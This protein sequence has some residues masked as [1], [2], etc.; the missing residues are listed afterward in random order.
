MAKPLSILDILP[1]EMVAKIG[2]YAD[3]STLYD[4]RLSCKSM[5]TITELTFAKR[6]FSERRHIFS[7]H[8]LEELVA[9]TAHPVFGRHVRT[10]M[11]GHT[12]LSPFGLE[13][14]SA[15]Y[16]DDHDA[17]CAFKEYSDILEE[18]K[19]LDNGGEALRLL[20]MAMVNIASHHES[21]V[22][23]SWPDT[24]VRRETWNP[25][26]MS[27]IR[28]HWYSCEIWY[29]GSG[30]LQRY[31]NKI[32]FLDPIATQWIEYEDKP[33]AALEVLLQA[34]MEAGCEVNTMKLCFDAWKDIEPG[35]F[36]LLSEQAIANVRI[37]DIAICPDLEYLTEVLSFDLIESIL[38]TAINVHTVMFDLA[39][40][41][42]DDFDEL[43]VSSIVKTGKL[44]RLHLSNGMLTDESL[45][46]LLERQKKSLQ[47]LSLDAVLV[48]GTQPENDESN[49]I[50]ILPWMRQNLLSLTRLTLKNMHDFS[51]LNLCRDCATFEGSHEIR[52]G[53]QN[54]LQIVHE[55]KDGCQ[56][57]RGRMRI[58]DPEFP[59]SE[60]SS[61]KPS[62]PES[63]DPAA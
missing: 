50:A 39:G 63:S 54:L 27:F 7:K 13:S 58:L 10:V 3:K 28:Y 37:I 26:E 16:D 46:S 23:G 21:I 8:S 18:Q 62:L 47:D 22:I 36:V 32:L 55:N 34:A 61:P 33:K 2:D 53:F 48:C 51:F 56:H 60:T 40:F 35:P 52:R 15:M 6:Y 43:G 30:Q 57:Y 11:L 1:V 49:W 24:I 12:R 45:M 25:Q 38:K 42:A 14:F 4:L 41:G 29:S 59:L 31:R 44:Q 19:S 17:A 20:T 9:I 5:Q